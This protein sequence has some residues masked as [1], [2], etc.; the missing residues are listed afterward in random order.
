M[1]SNVELCLYIHEKDVEIVYLLIYADDMLICEKM[2][3][4][5]KNK[6]IVI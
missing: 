4:N 2:K 6:E 5:T 3:K 1:K